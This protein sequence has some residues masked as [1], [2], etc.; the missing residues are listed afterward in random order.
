MS[1]ELFGNGEGTKSMGVDGPLTALSY[2][3]LAL[4]NLALLGTLSQVPFLTATSTG[5]VQRSLNPCF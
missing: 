4:Y 5:Y 1:P 2:I 3:P